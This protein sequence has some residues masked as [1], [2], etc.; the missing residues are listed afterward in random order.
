M[1]DTSLIAVDIEEV[2]DRLTLYAQNLTGAFVCL[3]LDEIALPGGESAGD[4][5]LATLLKFLDPSDTSVTWSE[6]RGQPTTSSVYVYLRKVLE[7]D[8]L[9]LMKKKSYQTTV[10]V[11]GYERESAEDEE[12][13][14]ITLEQLAVDFGTPE[15][16]MRKLERIH[17]IVKEFEDEPELKEIIELQMDPEGYNAFTNQELAKLLDTTVRDI[18]ARKKRIKLRLKRILASMSLEAKHV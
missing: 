7:H 15:G 13:P 8:F 12:K 1:A 18:E 4:L 17:K 2:L 16:Q 14:A 9:D 3:G 10:Y 11:D 6:S 5:A